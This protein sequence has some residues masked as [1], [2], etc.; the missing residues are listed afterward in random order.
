MPKKDKND[1]EGPD[2]RSSLIKVNID[3]D[4]V[5]VDSNQY[6]PQVDHAKKFLSHKNGRVKS[7]VCTRLRTISRSTSLMVKV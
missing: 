2:I 5:F 4:T 7:I 3:G 1:Q 6:K